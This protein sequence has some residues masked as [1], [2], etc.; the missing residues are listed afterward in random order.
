MSRRSANWTDWVLL[1]IIGLLL[2]LW[3]CCFLYLFVFRFFHAHDKPRYQ[4]FPCVLSLLLLYTSQIDWFHIGVYL[5]HIRC[6][7]M[8]CYCFIRTCIH[9]KYV[10]LI[11]K[12]KIPYR[13][14][15]IHLDLPILK[16][17]R[18]RGDMIEV[19]KITHRT[20]PN[21]YIMTPC[22]LI[23]L[24]CSVVRRGTLVTR[25]LQKISEICPGGF[26][27]MRLD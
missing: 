26:W 25:S 9:R 11:I 8:T 21:M 18:L 23:F 16:Y 14:R 1:F 2:F 6:Q 24:Y 10:K 15:P 17:R 4:T 22:F 20:N 5:V 3:C 27:D 13:D 19:F 7:F 12:Q